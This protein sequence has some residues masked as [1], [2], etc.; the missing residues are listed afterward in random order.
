MVCV[1]WGGEPK[2]QQRNEET[3]PDP[4]IW[5]SQIRKAALRSSE[6]KW[7]LEINPDLFAEAQ[8]G[9]GGSRL[10]GSQWQS[11]P[12]LPERQGSHRTRQSRRTPLPQLEVE[13]SGP[14]GLHGSGGLQ[15]DSLTGRAEALHFPGCVGLHFPTC[16]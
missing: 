1:C 3:G 10:H 7:W 15:W 13:G 12:L 2:N 8:S 16:K 6:V 14:S 4:G 5:A 11:Q 9:L